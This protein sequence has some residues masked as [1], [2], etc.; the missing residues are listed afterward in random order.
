L[1][2]MRDVHIHIDAVLLDGVTVTDPGVFRAAL[3]ATLTELAEGHRGGYLSGAEQVLKGE[4][5]QSNS[6]SMGADVARSAWASMIPGGA[7]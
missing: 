2:L 1:D 6:D 4:P 5:V 3:E 7:R